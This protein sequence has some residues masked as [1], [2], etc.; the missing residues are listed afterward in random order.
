MKFESNRRTLNYL[1]LC[2]LILFN[3][4]LLGFLVYVGHNLI[5][6]TKQSHILEVSQDMRNETLPS[7][8]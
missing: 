1:S 7:K 8:R 3:G 5:D 4:V 2:M 6:S